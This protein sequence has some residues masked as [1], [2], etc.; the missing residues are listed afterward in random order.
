MDQ[1][2]KMLQLLG[3]P[4]P[5]DWLGLEALPGYKRLNL[6][7]LPS[8]LR[9]RFAATAGFGQGVSLTEAGFDLLSR[10]LAWDPE[11]RISAAEALQHRWFTEPP[12]PVHKVLMPTFAPRKAG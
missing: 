9:Q 2:D 10:M 8:T 12:L 4:T 7:R 11:K 3:T 1:I 6:K 5:E